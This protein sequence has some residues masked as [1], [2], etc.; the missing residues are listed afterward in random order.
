M[1]VKYF[2]GSILIIIGI[3]LLLQQTGLIY[4]GNIWDFWPLLIIGYGITHLAKNRHS[5]TSG[6][7]IIIVGVVFQVNQFGWM[8]FWDLF[9]PLLLVIIG[10]SMIFKKSFFPKN[11][12]Q[13]NL[14]LNVSAVF[15][16]IKETIVNN[17]F[18][19]GSVSTVFGSVKLDLRSAVISA[20]GA[21][22]DINVAFGGV[23]LFVPPNWEII[24]IGSPIFG[25]IKN[26]SYPVYDLNMIKPKMV[27]NC[28]VAFGGVEIKS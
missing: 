11:N 17:N 10:L 20:D 26:K 7:I 19:G 28:S 14:E 25:D 16:S 15:S 3:L 5:L 12:E 18:R 1:K 4:L 2:F 6:L 23:V 9:L 13:T 22:L 8:D 21:K 27:L 24:I